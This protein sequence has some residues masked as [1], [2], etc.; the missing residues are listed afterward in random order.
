MVQRVSQ[1]GVV[2]PTVTMKA[3]SGMRA[4]LSTIPLKYWGVSISP[5]PVWLA[6][7]ALTTKLNS[8]SSVGFSVGVG[9]IGVAVS[10]GR[11]LV[12]CR[13][14]VASGVVVLKEIVFVVLGVMGNGS[15]ESCVLVWQL[16]M[17]T[18]SRLRTI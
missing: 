1:G 9:D 15:L 12:L 6:G 17:K 10:V 8:G 16:V 4:M 2:S 13:E 14:G 3:T 5:G 7:S 18:H 11:L